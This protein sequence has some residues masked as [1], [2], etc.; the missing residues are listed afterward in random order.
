MKEEKSFESVDGTVVET[1]NTVSAE[2]DV[3]ARDSQTAISA[4]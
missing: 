1:L 3:E 4:D 2:D